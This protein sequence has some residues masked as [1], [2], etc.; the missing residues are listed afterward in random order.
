MIKTHNMLLSDRLQ[1]A[2]WSPAPPYRC[3]LITPPGRH[4]AID[5]ADY[6]AAHLTDDI[7]TACIIHVDEG[8]LLF[9][10]DAAGPRLVRME[11]GI[12]RITSAYGLYAGISPAFDDLLSFQANYHAAALVRSIARQLRMEARV[13]RFE[14]VVFP[15]LTASMSREQ[16]K[17]FIKR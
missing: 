10:S 11:E 3:V 15:A 13:V 17:I 5:N 4:E 2:A 1:S 8:L 16:K 12:R 14:S 7:R 9:L 6:L